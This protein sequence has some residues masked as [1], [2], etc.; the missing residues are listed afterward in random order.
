MVNKSSKSCLKVIDEKE[1]IDYEKVGLICGI[2]I[3]QQL[4]CGKLF[5]SCPCDVVPN[6]TL[7]SQVER[8]LRFSLSETGEVDK[9]ALDEF[10]KGKS[11][12]Y[13]YNDVNACLID[14]DEEPII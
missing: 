4:N 6:D 12:V 8:K 2:E 5:C 3:H 14:L 7:T 11:N 1:K 9:A 13:K 10:R